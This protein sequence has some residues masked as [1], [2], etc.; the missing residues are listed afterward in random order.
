MVRT[1]T[2]VLPAAAAG[3]R[4]LG[5]VTVNRI[6]FGATT[7]S[8]PLSGGVS[9]DRIIDRYDDTEMNLISNNG[10]GKP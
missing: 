10:Q 6:G 7:S 2:D 4:E 5:G 9:N 8:A 1:K 3:S